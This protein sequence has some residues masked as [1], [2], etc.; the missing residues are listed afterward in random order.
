MELVERLQKNS[1]EV[2]F[3]SF[4]NKSDKEEKVERIDHLER[5]EKVV[6]TKHVE[7]IEKIEQTKHVE[8]IKHVEQIKHVDK[9]DPVQEPEQLE[10]FVEEAP[11]A[12]HIESKKSVYDY[13]I[14]DKYKQMN[15]SKDK[16]VQKE[17]PKV[18]VH[19]QPKPL[20]T[21]KNR[22][23]DKLNFENVPLVTLYA[24][25]VQDLHNFKNE[26]IVR[27]YDAR[28]ELHKKKKEAQKREITILLAEEQIKNIRETNVIKRKVITNSE[29]IHHQLKSEPVSAKNNV[30]LEKD[31]ERPATEN[32]NEFEV[33]NS[34]FNKELLSQAPE[35]PNN[36]KSELISNPHEIIAFENPEQV[37]RMNSNF[38]YGDY[39]GSNP[40]E[41]K[42]IRNSPKAEVDARDKYVVK[43][44]S[45]Q[46][47]FKEVFLNKET[48][49]V[50]L[51]T[52]GEPKR[53][54]NLQPKHPLVYNANKN[55][56]KNLNNNHK[57]VVSQ[58]PVHSNTNISSH[59]K[60]Y[61]KLVFDKD[62]KRKYEMVTYDPSNPP[63][64][65]R[66][67]KSPVANVKSNYANPNP[68][69][70]SNHNSNK[71]IE[72][73]PNKHNFQRNYV[74]NVRSPTPTYQGNNKLNPSP[75][76]K[77]IY[78][79]YSNNDQFGQPKMTYKSSNSI[80]AKHTTSYKSSNNLTHSPY[81]STTNKT[82]TGHNQAL[83]K[84]NQFKRNIYTNQTNTYNSYK[85]QQNTQ[86]SYGSNSSSKQQRIYH[87]NN[88]TDHKVIPNSQRSHSNSYRALNQKEQA[89]N[90][91]APFNEQKIPGKTNQNSK[92]IV[93]V[94]NGVRISEKI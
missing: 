20:Q 89:P 9:I 43:K 41:N 59:P 39:R 87:N 55:L 12:K 74:Q 86:V 27:K 15:N 81:A 68:Y 21:F 1:D 93:I 60:K 65:E 13:V 45:H 94:R 42:E 90:K 16:T 92:N 61:L 29:K 5:I 58:P 71:Q 56:S 19:H 34:K 44:D 35:Y 32:K 25:N 79:T 11:K 50:I 14:T 6:Q 46:N 72:G 22:E 69:P 62:G 75:A 77:P 24:G 38:T 70:S 48:N 36:V 83:Y 51:K 4:N 80:Q 18:I 66:N 82:P 2:I 53:S 28:K 31:L 76:P 49:E 7:R 64:S 8:R 84:N 85:S 26:R 78:K 73:G 23:V 63:Q 10:K 3:Q 33:S 54:P 67:A 17:D 52:V 88:P 91:Y 30:F 37:D 57:K 47:D 40:S